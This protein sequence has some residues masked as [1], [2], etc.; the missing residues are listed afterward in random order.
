[1]QQSE[2]L[3]LYIPAPEGPAVILTVPSSHKTVMAAVLKWVNTGH[4]KLQM[5]VKNLEIFLYQQ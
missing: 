3:F 5:A 4:E 2:L 1:V